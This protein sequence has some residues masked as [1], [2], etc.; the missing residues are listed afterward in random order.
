A[1]IVADTVSLTAAVMRDGDRCD[2]RVDRRARVGKMCGFEAENKGHERDQ[3][4][5]GELGFP[6][7]HRPGSPLQRGTPAEVTA[8]VSA[9]PGRESEDGVGLAGLGVLLE[10]LDDQ[11]PGVVDAA[12]V[13][14]GDGFRPVS[15]AEG[16]AGLATLGGEEVPA[17]RRVT[18]VREVREARPFD[19]LAGNQL[20]DPHPLGW[21]AK[22]ETRDRA[23][24]RF[25]LAL[26]GPEGT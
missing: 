21:A 11:A 8:L 24:F 5:A 6:G 2:L 7:L 22:A 12:E 3:H 16:D 25:G 26:R 19:A 17:H 23:D 20:V 13:V 10:A 15:V 14:L 1:C 18:P 4:S 9:L